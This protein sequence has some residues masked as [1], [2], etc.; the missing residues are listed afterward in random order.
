VKQLEHIGVGQK[1]FQVRRVMLA[2]HK[3]DQM[4]GAITAGKLNHAQTI[5][6]AVEA[7]GLCI[8]RHARPEIEIGG[9]IAL[10]E[11]NLW[12]GHGKILNSV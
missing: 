9:N 1:L 4:G 10:M 3:L 2:G 5:T 12:L 8:H 6:R 7:E 11:C